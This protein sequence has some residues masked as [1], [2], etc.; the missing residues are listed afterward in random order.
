MLSFDPSFV[1]KSPDLHHREGICHFYF[2]NMV[3]ENPAYIT[4][5]LCII[6]LA[7]QILNI[8]VLDMVKGVFRTSTRIQTEIKLDI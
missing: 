1:S 5:D 2:F 3:K 8:Y 4:C 6:F 7:I